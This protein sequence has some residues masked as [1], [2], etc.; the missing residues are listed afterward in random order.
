MNNDDFLWVH[1]KALP[2]FR[3]LLRA[4][5]A[6]YYQEVELPSPVLDVG[7]GDGHF[8][9]VVFDRPLEIG[10]DPDLK[11]L[12]EARRREAYL[13]LIQSDGARLPYPDRS[14]GSAISNSVLE[15]IPHLDAVL[16][17]VGRVLRP[18]APFV[19]TVP[20]PGYRDELSFPN[21]LKRFGLHSAS[22]A[23]RQWFMRMSRTIHMYDREQWQEKLLQAGFQV[24]HT[25]DYFAPSALHVLEWGHYFGAPSL[26]P[27]AVSGRWI[28]A[29]YRWN[30]WLTE[31]F[32]R[33][34][35]D[36]GP[37]VDGTYS[38]YLA[39]KQ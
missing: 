23:Y 29:P 20:N 4:V 9:S 16:E 24:E 26:L 25:F 6:N 12:R 19:F 28:A 13:S 15:H 36:A 33:R 11:S 35:Y 10:I 39:R 38:F 27:R 1:L 5:E 22:N 34:Y 3:S 37:K 30:L 31:R 14:I 2:F 7:C 21:W 32:V 8:A 18:G 17:D